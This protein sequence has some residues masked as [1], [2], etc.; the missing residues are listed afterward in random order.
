MKISLATFLRVSMALFFHSLSDFRLAQ[1]C[2]E[3]DP[4]SDGYA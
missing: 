4:T 2:L 1:V 3:I